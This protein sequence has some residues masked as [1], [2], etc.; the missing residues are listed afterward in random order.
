MNQPQALN[1]ARGDGLRLLLAVLIVSLNLRGAITC[2]GPL[3][4]QIR[5][6]LDLNATAAGLLSSLPLFA[7]ALISPY[8][9]P[10]ARRIGIEYAILLSLLLL[11]TG[12]GIRH[13]PSATSLYLGTGFIG[14][15]IAISNV[16]LP[17]LLR[18]EFPQQ[19]AV[20]TAL[21]TMVLV[22][23]GGLGSGI[24]IPLAGIGGWKFSLVAWGLPAII[25]LL[26]WLPRLKHNTRPTPGPEAR[27][28]LWNSSLAWQ[29]SLFMACQSTAFYVMI[30]WLPSM[31]SDLEGISAAQSGWILF[32]Y[33]IFVLLSVMVV[34][35]LIHRLPDQRW[36]G[37]SCASLIL[38][39]YCG[40]TWATANAL[41]WMILMGLGAGGS[42][43]LAMTLFGL[44]AN[45]AAQ[46]VALSGM[47]QTVAYTM[48]ALMPILIGYIHDQSNSWYVPLLMMIGVCVMQVV[49]GFLSGRPLSIERAH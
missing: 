49:T 20:V 21:F 48:A 30:A 45:S 26:A 16:L 7:F 8:A 25:G 14:T 18:R 19:L 2:V 23:M 33:Q 17:G 29:V 9:A 39:G 11:L 13:L 40:I 1:P 34:P 22:M 24:A 31:L 4:E 46:T 5:A 47:A 36:I 32:I 44:R 43:V 27:T 37:T 35:L 6:A 10:L 15:G 28:P 12:L 41:W 38:L 42:L 3:L